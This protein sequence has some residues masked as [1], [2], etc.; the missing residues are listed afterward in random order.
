VKWLLS[1]VWILDCGHSFRVDLKELVQ[2]HLGGRKIWS[3]IKAAILGVPL[4]LCSCG[5]I[6][7][8]ASLRKHG[9]S[10]GATSAFLLSTPQTGV[11][12]ILVT[13]SLLG[14][15]MAIFRP[16]VAL[17]TGIIGGSIITFFEPK[18]MSNSEKETMSCTD[19]CCTGAEKKGRIR[20]ILEF[21][22]FTL[23]R[24]LGKA[25]IVGLVIAGLISAMIPADYFADVLGQNSFLSM[26]LMMLVGIPI[27]VCAT[28]SVPLQQL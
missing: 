10:R 16:L 15:A 8:A 28:A 1:S 12:S 9:A 19:S 25:L 3:V 5:V 20:Q 18:A 22:F 26:I 4:P 14:V 23:P 17:L 7:V 6:P 21:G 24:D 11:D 27:Y 13:Y 2:R